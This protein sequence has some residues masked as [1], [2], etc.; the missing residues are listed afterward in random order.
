MKALRVRIIDAEKRAIADPNLCLAKQTKTSLEVLQSGK[1]ISHLLKACQTLELSTQV[2]VKCCQAFTE[3]QASSVLFGLIRSCNRSTPH[4]EVLRHALVVLLNVARHTQLAAFV[5][6]SSDSTDVLVDL[7]Q[8]F[9]DKQPIF[10]LS[11]ELLGRLAAAS[12]VTKVD[13]TF[14]PP[15]IHFFES[16]ISLTPIIASKQTKIAE[17]LQLG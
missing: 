14:F 8:M 4:Q 11:C 5:A 7:M 9:R 10:S 16:I 17:H 15:T 13:S 2:S 12:E 3:A 6:Q 1:M